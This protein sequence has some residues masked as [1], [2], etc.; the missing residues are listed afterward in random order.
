MN[1]KQM[2]FNIFSF[3]SSFVN[4]VKLMSPVST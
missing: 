2:N 1:G 4:E 3:D